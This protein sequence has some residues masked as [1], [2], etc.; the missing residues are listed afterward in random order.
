[1]AGLC[2][3]EQQEAL[4]SEKLQRS[5]WHPGEPAMRACVHDTPTLQTHAGE[6]MLLTLGPPKQAAS[7]K[8]SDTDPSLVSW[9]VSFSSVSKVEASCLQPYT[10]T[11][12]HVESA[13]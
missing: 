8:R 4:L 2:P 9:H 10:A 3:A 12:G 5:L 7:M 6:A 1:V 11:C 13:A